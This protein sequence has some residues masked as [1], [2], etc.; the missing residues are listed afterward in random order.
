MSARPET[1]LS[2]FSNRRLVG[3]IVFALLASHEALA[4][5]SLLRENPTIDEVVHLPAG[6]TY[7]QKGTFKLYRHNPPLIKL[8]AGLAVILAKPETAP[9]YRSENGWLSEYPSQLL[10]AQDFLIANVNRYF[11]LFAL[12]RLSL[13]LF[14]ILGGLV[15]F[16]WSRRLYGPAGGLLSL[17]LWCFC[18]NVLA[19]TR[20]VTTDAGATVLGCGASYLFWRY[21]REP[22][23]YRATFTGIALGLAELAKFS[24][25]LLYLLWPIIWLV[26]RIGSD[27]SKGR[28]KPT[29]REMLQGVAIVGLSI[30][31]IDAGYLFEGVGTHL[32]QFDF[33]SRTL[34]TRPTT[35]R[36][37]NRRAAIAGL[38]S[39]NELIDI[40]WRHRINRFR[41]TWLESLPSPLP[42]HYLLGFDEQKIEAD[43]LPTR[44][45]D[46]NTDPDA[47]IGYPVYLDGVL[48]RHGWRCYYLMTLLYKVPEGTWFLV[49][50]GIV[51]MF[52]SQRSRARWADEFTVWLPPVAVLAAM[53]FLTDINLGLRYVLPMFPYVFI[54]TGKLAPW[55]AGLTGRTRKIVLGVIAAGLLS[56]ALATVLIFPSF[57]AYFNWTSGGPRHGHEHLIDSNLDWG[58]DLVAL[59][60]WLRDHPQGKPVGVAYFGQI[61]PNIFRAQGQGF[62]WFL[63]PMQP[64][65]FEPM[66]DDPKVGPAPSLTPGLYAISASLLHGVPWRI[67]D[68]YFDPATSTWVSPAWSTEEDAFGYFRELTPLPESLGYS[69]L[70]YQVS[71]ADCARLNRKFWPSAK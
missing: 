13:S 4:V 23:W 21:L 19:H 33:A 46:P 2:I 11:E 27:P 30:L 50:L 24:L 52:L 64:G 65:R 53:S 6:V 59:R 39:G 35:G 8:V 54:A 32:G 14:S 60:S 37:E 58:Q 12:A 42:L 49:G 68:P 71:P 70:L 22:T 15:V 5:A 17:A 18:P 36:H 55:S 9:I 43:G 63:P 1:A 16:A 25:L 10:V 38:R 3:L 61:P 51:V 26:H 57:L 67:Y 28:R 34:L 66:V 69:I 20:L 29:G 40:S 44:W 56:T 41:G 47:V 48:R 62:D 45:V 31:T 7:W